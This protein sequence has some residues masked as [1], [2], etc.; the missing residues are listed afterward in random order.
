MSVIVS[1][2]FVK[3]HYEKIVLAVVLVGLVVAVALLPIMIASEQEQIEQRRNE[4]TRIPPKPLTNLD[5]G[6]A[7]DLLERTKTPITPVFSDERHN[8]FSPVRWSKTPDGKWVKMTKAAEGPDLIEIVKVTPLYLSVTL[9]SVSQATTN[10]LIKVV[11]ETAESPSK[12]SVSR[13]LAVGEKTDFVTL[14]EVKGPLEKPTEL[15]I[16]IN[17][18]GEIVTITPERGFKRIDGYAVDLRYGPS[19]RVWSNRRKG[20][21]IA[22]AGDVFTITSINSVATNEFELVLSSKSTGK[23]TVKRYKV[24]E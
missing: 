9:E 12:R 20:D 11:K 24:A 10:Y 3:K 14:R 21:T 5:L 2:A 6:A 17:E 18:T 16:E 19:G 8:L 7:W 4:I 13:Y 22:F 1:L 15:V 23:K